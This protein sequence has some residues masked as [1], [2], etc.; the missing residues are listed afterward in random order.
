M[1]EIKPTRHP[2]AQIALAVLN[3]GHPGPLPRGTAYL[4]AHDWFTRS[5][6]HFFHGLFRLPRE[7]T[8]TTNR[9]NAELAT[10]STDHGLASSARPQCH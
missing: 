8:M 1:T 9:K 7:A 6:R 3:T 4:G 10:I 2:L 5:L